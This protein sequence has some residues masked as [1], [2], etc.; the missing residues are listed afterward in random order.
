MYLKAN[1]DRR[2]ESRYTF[3]TYKNVKSVKKFLQS[4]ITHFFMGERL[5]MMDNSSFKTVLNHWREVNKVLKK[6]EFGNFLLQQL[7]TGQGGKTRKVI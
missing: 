1:Y 7:V 2:Y 5:I 6:R 3:V 4:P